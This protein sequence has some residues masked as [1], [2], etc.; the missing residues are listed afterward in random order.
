MKSNS[1]VLLVL[2]LFVFAGGCARRNKSTDEE[3]DGSRGSVPRI[4]DTP[5]KA[6]NGA[7]TF[8]IGKAT[9]YV[10]G[11]LDKNGYIDY[12]A[13]LDERLSKD[14]TTANNANALLWK[15]IGP[16]LP[17]ATIPDGY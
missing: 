6:K 3:T 1:I 2:S 17:P 9:T 5:I 8:T 12:A 16:G 13:A 10:T 11:P 14:V 15:A 4:A 7:G